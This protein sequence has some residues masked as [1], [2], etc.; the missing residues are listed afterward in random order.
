MERDLGY[1]RRRNQEWKQEMDAHWR[2]SEEERRQR[3]EEWKREMDAYWHASEAQ[4]LP[5]K[6]PAL[7]NAESKQEAARSEAKNQ[8]GI[9]F[10]FQTKDRT[11]KGASEAASSRIIGNLVIEAV[12]HRRRSMFK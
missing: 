12:T 8:R 7:G 11:Q 2:A 6:Q 4:R 5:Q 10:P 3:E 9:L 1:L